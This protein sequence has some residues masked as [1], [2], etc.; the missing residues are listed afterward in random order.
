MPLDNE[1]HTL[2]GVIVSSFKAAD[3]GVDEAL[4]SGST[5]AQAATMAKEAAEAGEEA[6]HTLGALVLSDIKRIADSLEI[7]A[8]AELARAKPLIPPQGAGS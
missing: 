6:L 4:K 1:I 8:K 5:V 7:L 3:R 2:L